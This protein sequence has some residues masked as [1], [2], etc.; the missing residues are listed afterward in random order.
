MNRECVIYRTLEIK[1]KSIK[2]CTDVITKM[3]YYIKDREFIKFKK[4]FESS[5]FHVDQRD[6]NQDTLLIMAV[7]SNCF[8]IVEFLLLKE[9][10]INL[11]DRFYNTPLHYALKH[12]HFKIANLLISKRPDER[13]VNYKGF[14]PWMYLNNGSESEDL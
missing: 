8:E 14:T 5:N 4:L 10:N 12:K 6:I 13:A 11:S 1:S 9:A 2:S 7:K 3:K